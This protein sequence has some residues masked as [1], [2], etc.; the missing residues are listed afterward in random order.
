MAACPQREIEM[1]DHQATPVPATGSPNPTMADLPTQLGDL[2][3]EIDRIDDSIHDLLMRRARVVE[4]VG[5]LARIG[6][7]P[8]RPGRE[9]A[10]IRRLLAR[11]SGRLPARA[12]PRVWREIFAASIAIE[13]RFVIAA[14]DSGPD[15]PLVQLAREHFGAL[16]ALR[17]AAG[18]GEAL[19]MVAA[20][21]VSA[22][23]LPMP[24]A[25]GGHWWTSLRDAHGPRLHVVAR[26]P[27]WGCPRP[28]GAIAMLALVVAVAPP[29][30]SGVDRSLIVADLA[31]SETMATAATVVD[32]D[33]GGTGWALL[34]VDGLLLGGQGVD[35]PKGAVVVGGYALPVEDE[36]P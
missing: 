9:A 10:I 16:T 17:V 22:A 13:Q 34:E 5:E 20:G 11:H 2:R 19:R 28:E 31:D 25:T 4:R 35:R 29:D 8:F 18:P 3:A 6:K 24:G 21:E 12:I 33:P 32:R 26:L 15:A 36:A 27:F 23:V 14:C 30:A 7:V 1:P